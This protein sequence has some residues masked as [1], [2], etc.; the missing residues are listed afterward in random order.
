MGDI[1]LNVGTIIR[2]LISL[3]GVESSDSM[4]KSFDSQ[5]L[6]IGK[7]KKKKRRHRYG[8]KE[9]ETQRAPLY[10][11]ISRRVFLIAFKSTSFVS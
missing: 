7:K 11:I 5:S 8:S 1:Y 9:T 10:G 3:S 4:S 2:R 6:G